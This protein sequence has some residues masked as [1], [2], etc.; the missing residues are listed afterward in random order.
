VEISDSTVITCSSEIEAHRKRMTAR[1]DSQLEKM[2]ATHLEANPE[3][4]WTLVLHEEV[5]K[6]EAA[7]G[8][9]SSRRAPRSAEETDPG[10]W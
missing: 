5:P 9:G 3:E 1:I 4:K 8:P 7:W 2:V 10:K 6:E